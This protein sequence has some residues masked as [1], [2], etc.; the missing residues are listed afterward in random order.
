MAE[1]DSK[2]ELKITKNT[3]VCSLHF[4]QQDFNL[5]RQDGKISRRKKC[6][7]VNLQK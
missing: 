1:K 2:Q 6:A 3:R 4:N 7:S 5:E